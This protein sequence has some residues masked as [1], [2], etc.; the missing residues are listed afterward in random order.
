MRNIDR[1]PNVAPLEELGVGAKLAFQMF[2]GQWV[3]FEVVKPIPAGS[4]VKTPRK[5]DTVNYRI[6][7]ES[8]TNMNSEYT[9]GSEMK[10]K[11]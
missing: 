2:E 11:M 7:S 1:I 10:S 5:I 3:E 9:K 8:T 4:L 6:D